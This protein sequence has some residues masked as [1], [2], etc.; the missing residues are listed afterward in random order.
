M[1]NGDDVE[2]LRLEVAAVANGALFNRLK[3]SSAA[4]NP[5][6][7]IA[8]VVTLL[9]AIRTPAKTNPLQVIAATSITSVKAGKT[10]R[11]VLSVPA[12]LAA[13]G[14]FCQ[15]GAAL[16][17]VEAPKL[18]MT[19]VLRRPPKFGAYKVSRPRVICESTRIA[20]V[21]EKVQ[22]SRT[23]LIPRCLVIAPVIAALLETEVVLRTI[24]TGRRKSP[25]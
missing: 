2:E 8:R 13:A 7:R 6:T 15:S 14:C 11:Y 17:R 9:V 24:K 4:E 19:V 22:P 20:K 10:C 12:H 21:R 3:T 25:S 1:R 23:R 5:T 18:G 16:R